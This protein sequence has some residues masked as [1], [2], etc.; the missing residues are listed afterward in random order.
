MTERKIAHFTLV[1][2]AGG[3]FIQ[4]SNKSF[5][6]TLHKAQDFSLLGNVSA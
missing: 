4:A 1:P 2:K 5:L 6:D 3:I